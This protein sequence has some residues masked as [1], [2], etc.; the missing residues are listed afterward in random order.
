[1]NELELLQALKN[2]R[3]SGIAAAD[4]GDDCVAVAPRTIATTDMLLDGV[5][6]DTSTTPI[7]LIA[8]KAV[9]V[10]LS[11]L[12]ASGAIPTFLLVSLSL[13]RSWN[14]EQGL[15]LMMSIAN[16][17]AAFSCQIKGGDTNVWNGPLVINI[18]AIGTL[19]W[20]GQITRSGAKPGD[21]LFVTG[22]LG[23]SLLSG[24]HLGFTPRVRESQ[25]LLDHLPIQSMM[26]LSDGLATDGRRLAEASKVDLV[27]DV[28]R[29][30]IHTDVNGSGEEQLDH[31]LCDGEDFE[32]LFCIEAKF[33]DQLQKNWPWPTPLSKIGEVLAGNGK[34]WLKNRS[35]KHLLTKNGFIHK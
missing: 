19:H 20:R 4:L 29:I 27:I 8:R 34:V 28:G 11:D 9:N 7:D 5:H 17:A 13:P 3:V 32:L 26:D 15:E 14:T 24:R 23:G 31:A 12:A 22:P 33:V 16:S 18:V 1:M 2:S 30:P 21:Q 35:E 10:N 6:F 25:W